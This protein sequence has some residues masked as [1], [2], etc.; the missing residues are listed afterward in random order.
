[1]QEV[2]DNAVRGERILSSIRKDWRASLA[3][4]NTSRIHVL[5]HLQNLGDLREIIGG[6]ILSEG[7][8]ERPDAEFVSGLVD[9]IITDPAHFDLAAIDPYQ[10]IISDMKER[11]DQLRQRN[12]R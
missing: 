2:V 9:Y 10:I 1:M 3:E 4:P 5:G 7:I 8:T 12:R 6:V 11:L